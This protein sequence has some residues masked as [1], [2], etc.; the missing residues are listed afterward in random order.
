[1]PFTRQSLL[2][3]ISSMKRILPLLFATLFVS[4][5]FHSSNKK[6]FDLP[7][8]EPTEVSVSAMELYDVFHPGSAIRIAQDLADPSANL[9]R[10]G[11]EVRTQVKIRNVSGGTLLLD[12]IQLDM[13]REDG[14]DPSS[15]NMELDSVLVLQDSADTSL[16]W[17][18]EVSAEDMDLQFLEDLLIAEAV[19]VVQATP[20]LFIRFGDSHVCRESEE[21]VDE[22]LG[23]AAEMTFTATAATVHWIVEHPRE[24]LEII[25]A[26]IS[27][28]LKMA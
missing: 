13:A 27:I 28:A 12:S 21:F 7:C 8:V 20:K 25:L 24:S 4:A 22:M 14:S 23:E 6:E 5:C 2:G 18:G 9:H 17:F 11:I 26:F 1:M 19:H 10:Y 15:M 3:Y 16:E